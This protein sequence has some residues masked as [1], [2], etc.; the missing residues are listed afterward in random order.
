MDT[1]SQVIGMNTFTEGTS[2]GFAIPSNSIQRIVPALIQN[3]SYSHPSLGLYGESMNPDIS[4]SFGLPRNF[5][6]VLVTYVVPGGP[7]STAGLLAGNSSA[8]GDIIVGIDGHPVKRMDDII[9]Y[10]EEHKSV[11]ENTTL[12]IIRNGQEINLTVVLQ[13][14]PQTSGE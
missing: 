13:A 10:L 12:T 11:G 14:R 7:S 3:G 5:K 4:V 1:Q 2:I 8:L 9:A 6:G